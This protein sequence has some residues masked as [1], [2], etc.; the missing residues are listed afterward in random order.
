MF[1]FAMEEIKP[2][3]ERRHGCG[4]W[5]DIDFFNYKET[6]IMTAARA[7]MADVFVRK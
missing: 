1:F 3:F 4:Y 5:P 2:A 6:I 7:V